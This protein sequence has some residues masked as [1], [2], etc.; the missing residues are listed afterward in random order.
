MLSLALVLLLVGCLRQGIYHQVE[1]GQTLYRISKTYKVEEAYLARI[2]GIP[3]PT[4]LR[5]GT[6]IFV[7]GAVA[8][9]Y[10]PA[11]VPRQ[12][13]L[14]K[15]SVPAT[16]A[17]KVKTPARVETAGKSASN[18]QK[19]VKTAST[20]P[21]YK[22]SSKLNLKLQW[23]LRGKI[24]RAFGKSGKGGGRGLEIAAREGTK[25]SAAAAGKVIYSGDGVQG[26][27]HLMILQHENDVF[28]VY[29]FNSQNHV[30]QG[31]FV[32]Q[33]QRIASSGRPPSGEA[34]RLHFEVRIGKLA[35]DPILYLP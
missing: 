33:G 34:G 35:V 3:N 12:S 19:R 27:G 21:S 14:K 5:V 7:P 16:K 1:P 23:P 13:A 4:R 22:K 10:V 32:S 28:T 29:G 11:T 25:V 24:L 2:N 31:Q 17:S 20:K 26:F 6:R 18:T 9:K 30:K 8:K 15:K